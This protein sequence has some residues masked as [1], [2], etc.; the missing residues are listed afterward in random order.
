[1]RSRWCDGQPYRRRLKF[2][3][4][5]GLAEEIA[6]PPLALTTETLWRAYRALEKSKVHGS[7]G[8]QLTDIVAV[9]RFALHQDQTLVP[10]AESVNERFARW[11]GAQQSQ[12]RTFTPEQMRW[13]E[14]IRDH[15]AASMTITVDDFEY[16]PFNE[17][18]G[19]GKVYQVFGGEF[20]KLLD[21]LNEVLAA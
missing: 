16:T 7:G 19:I 8:K 15:V 5:K 14:L 9:V 6:K 2:E 12:G 1:V 20:N 13:L 3:D 10:F 18:G 21:E 17:E 4:I 11:L